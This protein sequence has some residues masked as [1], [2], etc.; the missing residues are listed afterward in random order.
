MKSATAVESQDG[1]VVLALGLDL[2]DPGSDPHPAMKLAGRSW[3]SHYSQS[4]L[5]HKVVVRTEVR[6]QPCTTHQ[7]YWKK[8]SA[9]F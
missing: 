3:G 5:L 2:E 7:V 9:K 4:N 1:F 8:G 6:K